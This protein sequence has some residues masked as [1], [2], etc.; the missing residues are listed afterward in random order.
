MTGNSYRLLVVD[1]D[2]TLV[3]HPASGEEIY[4]SPIRKENIPG[5]IITANGH[6]YVIIKIVPDFP[7]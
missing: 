1:I 6:V 2:G 7:V 5:T 3:S 4:L